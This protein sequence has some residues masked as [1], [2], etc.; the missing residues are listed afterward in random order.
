MG[1]SYQGHKKSGT[2]E[3]LSLFSPLSI[4]GSLFKYWLTIYV[5]LYFWPLNS[6]P[7]VY[8]CVFDV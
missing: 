1:Y 7:L 5:W 4:L 3:Q 2:I 8:A 6:V